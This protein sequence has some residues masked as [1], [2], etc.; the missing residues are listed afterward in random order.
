[1]DLLKEGIEK[2][3]VID[4]KQTKQLSISGKSRIYPV[5]SIN[6]DQVFFNDQNDRIATWMSQYDMDN[7]NQS[8]D[9]LNR[10]DYNQIIHGFIV[11]SNKDAI[12]KTLKNIELIG[13]Q[14]AGVVLSDGR[15][16]DGNRRYTC[17]RELQE[18]TGRA[19]VFNAVILEHDIEHN[20][21]DI[22]MLELM[23]QHGVDEK[24]DYTPIER[25]VGVY[26][27]IVERKLLST[28]EY[29]NSINQPE[30][31]VKE[32]V[33]RGKLLVE[34][35]D[36]IKAPKQFYLARTMNLA[37][38]LKELF[39]ILKKCKNEEQ[40]EDIKNIVF[41]QFATTPEGD[42]T[43]YMRKI[44]KIASKPAQL[45]VYIE[46][47]MET[48]EKVCD[49]IESIEEITVETI[50]KNLS[51]QEEL[52][53]E[54]ARATEKNVAKV[55]QD[56]TRNLP[57]QLASKA[58]DSLEDINTDILIKLKEEQKV[59]LIDILTRIEE[60]IAEIKELSNV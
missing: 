58:L 5:Y 9:T 1:M 24:I 54:F 41:S 31:A 4:A 60:T 57:T 38:P 46:E 49:V 12:K 23:L 45:Q 43:R 15:I 34:Y 55:D 7:P 33:E 50:N 21:K 42:M 10:D 32:D 39:E 53:Q 26:K 47:T 19:Q 16:I 52:K 22:K 20:A 14:E 35:L 40:K 25:I 44:K 18:K 29:A 56:T 48:A 3:Y 36:F 59:E 2:N 27:D 51:N 6:L 30:K 17:L 28:K 11:E 8:L 13:Q 37:D